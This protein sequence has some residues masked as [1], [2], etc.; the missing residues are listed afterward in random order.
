[1]KHLPLITLAALLAPFSAHAGSPMPVPEPE[2]LSLLGIGIAAA[3][4]V[5][6]FRKKK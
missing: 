1:M 4:A 5:K 6:F 2:V 3:F